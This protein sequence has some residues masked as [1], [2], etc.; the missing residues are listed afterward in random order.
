MKAFKNMFLPPLSSRMAEKRGIREFPPL[1]KDGSVRF[2]E[3]SGKRL[4]I[5]GEELV[6]GILR[7][8][9]ERNGREEKQRRLPQELQAQRVSVGPQKGVIPICV[10]CKGIRDD[11]ER[12]HALE[13]FLREHI[14]EPFSHGICPD[15]M[16]EFYPGQVPP[17]GCGDGVTDA[18]AR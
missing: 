14:T 12:W 11:E 15:C 4:N 10:H 3:I 2:V 5:H 7:D 17:G 6:L 13:A 1:R 8:I 9:T 18:T 16:R